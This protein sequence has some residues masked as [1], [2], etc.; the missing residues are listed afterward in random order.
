M[1]D[2]VR[3]DDRS[4]R[5]IRAPPPPTST[6]IAPRLTSATLLFMPRRRAAPAITWP[7]AALYGALLAA[8]ALGLDWVQYQRLARSRTAD[9]YLLLVAAAFL[10]LGLLAGRL[11]LSRRDTP[12]PPGNPAARATL[13]ISDRELQ[14]L[15]ALADGQSNKEIAAALHIS[16]HTVKT[17]VARL[18]E[19][20]GARGRVDAL[21]RGRAIGILP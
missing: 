19:K 13:G 8:G 17:H 1:P 2:Q 12:P 15:E 11:L 10:V 6:H 9:L 18:Y 21:A 20:L 7:Q 5:I 4:V 14:V 16:P 3:H